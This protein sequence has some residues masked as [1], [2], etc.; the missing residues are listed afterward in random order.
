[1][2]SLPV[3]MAPGAPPARWRWA[4]KHPTL[5]IGAVV[6]ERDVWGFDGL[7]GLV[8]FG[9]YA[10]GIGSAL[11]ILLSAANVYLRDMQHLIE[12]VFTAW[13]TVREPPVE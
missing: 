5:I 11:G 8:M 10:A 7:Q 3:E 12:V 9:L 4:R 1:M 6:P 13:L 2:N